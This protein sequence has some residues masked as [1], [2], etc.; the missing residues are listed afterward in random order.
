MT[1]FILQ[2]I[3][4][5]GR[6]QSG[7]TLVQVIIASSLLAIL[8]VLFFRSQ[9]QTLQSKKSL[10]A[11]QGYQEINQIFVSEITEVLKNPNSPQCFTPES[12]N[13]EFSTGSKNSQI[14][15]IDDILEGSSQDMIDSVNQSSIIK[16]ARQRCSTK[17]VQIGNEYS[18]QDSK[19]HF[20]LKFEGINEL[21]FNS[22]LSSDL[23]FAEIAIHLKDLHTDEAI[24]CQDY[25]QSLS[26]GAQVFY[27]LYW[28]I[29]MGGEIQFK[30]HN[31]TFYMSRK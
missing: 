21:E 6:D 27:S 19:M 5:Q 10:R 7:F 22:L 18:P 3:K 25:K 16:G 9:V 15:F 23:A 17:I 14:N 11:N 28:A 26:A 20:C 13:I 24:S 8:G 29:P 12:F 30:R 31:G 2:L 4:R 1:N